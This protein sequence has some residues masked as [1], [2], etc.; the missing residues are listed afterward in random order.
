[1]ISNLSNWDYWGLAFPE[2][3]TSV[4]HHEKFIHFKW[5][6]DLIVIYQR[7]PT[8]FSTRL[9]GE[10]IA[11][12]QLKTLPSLKKSPNCM[13]T[14]LNT[15]TWNNKQP[16][17]LFITVWTNRQLVIP[18]LAALELH[19]LILPIAFLI[20]C[21][22]AAYSAQFNF[23][24]R[25]SKASH[26]ASYNDTHHFPRHRKL[27]HNPKPSCKSI[28]KACLIKALQSIYFN[29]LKHALCT[30]VCTFT[31]NLESSLAHYPHLCLWHPCAFSHCHV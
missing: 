10:T 17:T 2:L 14:D 3:K 22:K 9:W 18:L 29:V 15:Q 25:P 6:T 20:N 8:R 1:M 31:D 19:W 7:M 11:E 5:T 26:Q 16:K 27:L 4:L 12:I 30:S 28:L 21:W 13:M 23:P 24:T